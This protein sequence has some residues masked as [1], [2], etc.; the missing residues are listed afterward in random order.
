M[1]KCDPSSLRQLLLMGRKCGRAAA[2]WSSETDYILLA[3]GHKRLRVNKE[4]TLLST[5]KF[6]VFESHLPSNL[7]PAPI[8]SYISHSHFLILVSMTKGDLCWN[9]WRKDAGTNLH[10]AFPLSSSSSFLYFLSSP[11]FLSSHLPQM[12]NREDH[13]SSPGCEGMKI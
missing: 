5:S 1:R 4:Y 2:A 8:I 13:H 11:L 12:H 6:M 10:S 9:F 3:S 7:F